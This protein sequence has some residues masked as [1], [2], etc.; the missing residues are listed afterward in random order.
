MSCGELRKNFQS[1]QI[2]SRCL[3]NVALL[4]LDVRQII[5]RISMVRAQSGKKYILKI[6]L[7]KILEIDLF[8]YF[9]KIS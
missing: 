8:L 6:N 4:T 3:L 1:F 5:E 7:T 9:T 2:Q